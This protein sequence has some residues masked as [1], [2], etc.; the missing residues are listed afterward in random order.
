MNE[1]KQKVGKKKTTETT[2]YVWGSKDSQRVVLLEGV[3]I[4]R[5]GGGRGGW[6]EDGGGIGRGRGGGG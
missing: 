3:G 5:V 2:S 6:E 4:L 1:N